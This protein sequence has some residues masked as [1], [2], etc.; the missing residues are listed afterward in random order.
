MLFRSA[1]LPILGVATISGILPVGAFYIGAQGLGAARAALLST[2]EPV[3]TIVAASILFG[4]RLTAIQLAGGALILGA[5][6]VA[7]W[8]AIRPARAPGRPKSSRR[9]PR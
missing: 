6:F 5:V 7:E 1:I 8:E 4:E 2:I 3:Y 9:A